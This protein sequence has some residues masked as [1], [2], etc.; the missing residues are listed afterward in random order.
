VVESG[1][2][3][4]QMKRGSRRKRWRREI[5]EE[6][7]RQYKRRDIRD[8]NTCQRLHATCQ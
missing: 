3:A 4:H 5:G 2:P 8:V 7:H 6:I 1:T